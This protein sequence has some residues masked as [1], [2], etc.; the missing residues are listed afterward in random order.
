MTLT[1]TLRGHPKHDIATR[2]MIL[3]QIPMIINCMLLVALAFGKTGQHRVVRENLKQQLV[4]RIERILDKRKDTLCLG[5]FPIEMKKGQPGAASGQS[6]M[7]Q[8]FAANREG[9]PTDPRFKQLCH[10]AFAIFSSIPLD[11]LVEQIYRE[12]LSLEIEAPPLYDAVY[13]PPPPGTDTDP[14]TVVDAEL[15]AWAQNELIQSRLREFR[16]HVEEVQREAT[17]SVF[18]ASRAVEQ[19]LSASDQAVVRAKILHAFEEREL[20]LLPSAVQ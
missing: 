3:M 14:S 6:D 11:Q 5:A 2:W 13:L 17:L 9:F 16:H 10:E 8:H 18:H 4:I 7:V 19:E 12:A 1:T 15:R 20:V